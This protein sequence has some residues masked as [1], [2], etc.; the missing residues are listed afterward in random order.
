V[1]TRKNTEYVSRT[2][3]RLAKDERMKCL[4]SL[5]ERIP[6]KDN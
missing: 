1:L 6:T 3:L 4:G 2:P 5:S